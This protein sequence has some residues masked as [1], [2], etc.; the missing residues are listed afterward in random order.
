MVLIVRS[1]KAIVR[2]EV[3][4]KMEEITWHGQFRIFMNERRN[5]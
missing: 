4:G 5:P 2:L 1:L 3:S